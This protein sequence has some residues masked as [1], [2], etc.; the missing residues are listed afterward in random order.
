MTVEGLMDDGPKRRPTSLPIALLVLIILTAGGSF[1]GW[2]WW[3]AR[4]LQRNEQ[5]AV[6]LL[7]QIAVAEVDFRSNDR[8]E[9]RILDFWTADVVGLYTLV[10]VG[11]GRP[12]QLIER[13]LAEADGALPNPRPYRG[14]L[15]RALDVDEEG[16][17][18][19]QDTLG[20]PGV[21]P[22]RNYSKFA[23]CAYPAVYG[24]TGRL[25]FV[26][27]EG[28]TVFNVDNEGKPILTFP[29]DPILIQ[30]YQ[31]TD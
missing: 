13:A 12:I 11:G 7:K 5:S 15:F 2:R 29:S 24:R 8:D 6:M 30:Q 14:Y 3:R 18:Y 19:R 20:K 27:N 31:K 10:P 22:E 9:N 25:T 17:R 26:I 21:K 1:W 28:N 23:F 4:V 16:N